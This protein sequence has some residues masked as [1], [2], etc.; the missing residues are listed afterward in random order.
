MPLD[1]LDAYL[2]AT[3]PGSTVERRQRALAIAVRLLRTLETADRPGAVPSQVT[4]AVE[5]IE[6]AWAH[7]RP[8][9]PNFERLAGR[10][11][12]AERVISRIEHGQRLAA[13]M[14]DPA[15]S[16][17]AYLF[18]VEPTIPKDRWAEAL[19]AW[20]GE[21][22]TARGRPRRDAPPYPSG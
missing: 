11:V 2:E 16:C 14:G 15:S 3:A 1:E 8:L 9:S 22:A 17:A 10:F 5:G 4:A 20:R 13:D 12:F 21:I 7:F 18:D 6:K 19:T